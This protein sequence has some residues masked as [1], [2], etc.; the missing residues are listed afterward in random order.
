MQGEHGM[1]KIEKVNFPF[2]VLISVKYFCR[3]LWG[4]NIFNKAPVSYMYF[5][6]K[7]SPL[8]VY[9]KQ[10]KKISK[11]RK[12]EKYVSSEI[13]ESYFRV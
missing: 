13:I 11:L 1:A 6:E 8:I 4:H 7:M 10:Y 2:T 9:I 12:P 3:A 5:Y